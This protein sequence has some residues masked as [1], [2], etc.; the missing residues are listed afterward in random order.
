MPAP[1]VAVL[2]HLERPFGGGHAVAVLRDAGVVV[3]ERDMRRGEELPGLD[4]VDGIVSLGGEQS[5]LEH[6]VT[7]R[8]LVDGWIASVACWIMLGWSLWATLRAIGV[9]EVHPLTHLP[10]LVAASATLSL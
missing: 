7:G 10:V 5:V 8:L 2:H 6:Q 3:E 9:E 1:V 4:Q